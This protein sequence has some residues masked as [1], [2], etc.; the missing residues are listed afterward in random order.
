MNYLI[1][2]NRNAPYVK[3]ITALVTKLKSH[4]LYLASKGV[5]YFEYKKEMLLISQ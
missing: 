2:K 5:S 4:H 1:N 3:K